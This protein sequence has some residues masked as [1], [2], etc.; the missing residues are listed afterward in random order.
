MKRRFGIDID[1]TVTSPSTFVPYINKSFEMNIT[2]DDIKEYDLTPLLGISDKEFWKWMD[3]MEPQIYKES[4]LAD[5]ARDVLLS[6][7]DKHELIFISARRQ[8]LLEITEEWFTAQNLH[9]HHIELIGTHDKLK[10]VKKHA[11]EIFFEDK[12]D[13]ACAISEECNI[14]VILFNTPYNQ[15]PVPEG[16]IRVDSWKEAELWVNRWNS[17]PRGTSVESLK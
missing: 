12:H 11:V 7:K 8:H 17:V 9:Y 5:H 16:V 15:D 6:W 10:A 2:L 4:P 1:G 3:E 14:P 13:N